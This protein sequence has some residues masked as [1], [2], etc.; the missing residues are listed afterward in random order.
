MVLENTSWGSLSINEMTGLVLEEVT[1][2]MWHQLNQ[3][4]ELGQIEAPHSLPCPWNECS[5]LSSQWGLGSREQC[6]V[7]TI[8]T[9]QVT[10]L[11]RPLYKH[12]SVCWAVEVSTPLLVFKTSLICKF[13]CLLK[14]P[15]IWSVLPLSLVSSCPPCMGWQ[16][17]ISPRKFLRLYTNN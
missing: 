7:E 1:E 12:F 5:A 17:Q 9:V 8:W 14:L 3:D 11:L 4:L 10:T 16:F 13:P 6:V 15:S 2:K